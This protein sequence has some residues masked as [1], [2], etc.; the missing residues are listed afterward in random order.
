MAHLNKTKSIFYVPIH[1]ILR[2]MHLVHY[3]PGSISVKG[4]EPRG[5]Q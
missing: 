2:N 5:W 1:K 4:I 3:D